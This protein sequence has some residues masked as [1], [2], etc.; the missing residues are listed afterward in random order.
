MKTVTISLSPVSVKVEGSTKAEMLENAKKALIEQLEKQF[1]QFSYSVSEGEVLTIDTAHA[2]MIVECNEG[3]KGIITG[4]NQ[5]TINVTYSNGVSVSGSPQLFKPSE[6]T[7][8]EARSKRQDFM[9]KANMWTE[10]N[11]AYLNNK[12]TFIPVII[13]K[14]K[15]KKYKLYT[16]NNNGQHY[17]VEESQLKALVDNK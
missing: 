14:S 6:A 7:F 16:I 5:K 17:S 3:K 4:V 2:G 15:G 9:V 10:G 13:G 12:G 11:A 8:E 1:P